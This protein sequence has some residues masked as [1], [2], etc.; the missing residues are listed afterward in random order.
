M[1][2]SSD[3]TVTQSQPVKE[4][5][6]KVR[7]PS[8]PLYIAAG[9]EEEHL[10]VEVLSEIKDTLNF[11]EELELFEEEDTLE[12]EDDEDY[13]DDSTQPY[14]QEGDLPEDSFEDIQQ[15][16]EIEQL[17]SGFTSDPAPATAECRPSSTDVAYGPTD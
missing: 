4:A 12:K 15:T 14:L 3:E 10:I 13:E 11:L 5:S 16:D 2:D 17:P 6:E 7:L 8:E 9:D 1:S